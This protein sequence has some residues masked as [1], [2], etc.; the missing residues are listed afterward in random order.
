[1]NIRFFEPMTVERRVTM[2]NDGEAYRIEPQTAIYTP[3]NVLLKWG[4]FLLA[5]RP[6]SYMRALKIINMAWGGYPQFWSALLTCASS[7]LASQV[8]VT[9]LSHLS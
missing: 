1:M 6:E 4:P 5:D 3:A 8:S 7:S 2:Y 9:M